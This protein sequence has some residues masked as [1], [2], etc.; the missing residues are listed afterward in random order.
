MTL[1]AATVFARSLR[2]LLATVVGLSLA[3]PVA[4]D[5]PVETPGVPPG[6]FF[7]QGVVAVSHPLAAEAGARML[8]AGGNAFDA[9]AAIQFALNVVEP[10]FSGIG[11]G[12]FMMIHL[13]KTGETFMLDARERA[14]GAA[15][16]RT[17]G[18]PGCWPR[19]VG[20][21]SARPTP[22]GSPP[23]CRTPA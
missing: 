19:W 8:E 4:A 23:A 12:G 11:G 21:P 16:P 20:R 2:V 22:T 10:Q 17:P 6:K 3:L 9:A 5:P 13:G 14:P 7:R 18:S 1:S 15:T